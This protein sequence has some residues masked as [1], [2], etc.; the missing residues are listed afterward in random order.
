MSNLKHWIWLTQRQGLNEARRRQV[1]EHFGSPEGVYFA[2]EGELRTIGGLQE[3]AVRSL[4]DKSLTEADKVLENCDRLGARIMTM[5]DAIYPE[6]LRA[7][8]QPPLVLYWKG[9]EI[10]FDNEAVVAVVGTRKATPYGVRMASQLALD[11]S[12]AGALVLSGIAEG[13]D[14]AAVRTALKAGGRVVS[15]LGGGLDVIYPKFHRD[16]YADVASAGALITEYPPGTEPR[17]KHFPIRNRIISGLSLGVVVVESPD[18]G[19]SLSTARH[20][21]DQGREVFAVPGLAD[22]ENSVGTNR[23]IQ[24]G[25]AKLVMNVDDVLCEL[26]G[27][28]P[29]MLRGAGALTGEAREHR[30]ENHSPQAPVRKA[31]K[32]SNAEKEV[33]NRPAVEYIVWQ[34]WKDKLTNDQRDVLLALEEKPLS[35][36]DVVERMQIPARRVLAALTVLQ[37]QGL[38]AEESGKRFRAAVRLKME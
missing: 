36:D 8:Y 1:L 17:G 25:E 24:R 6:R 28:F 16:L 38:V 33:D 9:R 30:L 5:Q 21:L 10:A 18:T 37:I 3:T 15:V 26:G 2:D 35:A 14:A 32:R 13:I 22:G 12:R 29:R 27:Q 31:E 4:A 11:L 20:A 19:G 23:L 7:I 34:D